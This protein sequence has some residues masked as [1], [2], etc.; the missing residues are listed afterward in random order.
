VLAAPSGF[1][2]SFLPPKKKLAV[3]TAKQPHP[4]K[5]QFCFKK[6]GRWMTT[7]LF[8][9]FIQLPARSPLQR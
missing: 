1:L 4:H 7:A 5:T 8:L 9:V 6:E 3:A 2:V